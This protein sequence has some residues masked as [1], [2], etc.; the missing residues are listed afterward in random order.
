M[1]GSQL[2]LPFW[3]KAGPCGSSPNYGGCDKT[4]GDVHGC[5]RKIAGD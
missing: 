4:I 2:C 1:V 5:E 3:S